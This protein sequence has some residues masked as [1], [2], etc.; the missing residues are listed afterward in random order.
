MFV[1]T[2]F[3]L[4]NTGVS[5]YS[6]QAFNIDDPDVLAA[7]LAIVTIEVRHSGLIGQ[8][9]SGVD[10]IAPDGPLDKAV[11]A[12]KTLKAVEKTGFIVTKGK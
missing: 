12:K 1:A 5:A 7:A 4:E 3:A 11:G 10:G 6:G 9:L 2:S 8:I